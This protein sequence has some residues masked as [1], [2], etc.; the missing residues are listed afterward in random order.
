M[1]YLL[2]R[3]C[4]SSLSCVNGCVITGRGGYVSELSS[5]SNCSTNECFPDKSRWLWNEK[6]FLHQ[7]E[8]KIAHPHHGIYELASTSSSIFDSI[9]LMRVIAGFN[10]IFVIFTITVGICR[11]YCKH[12][13]LQTFLLQLLLFTINLAVATTFHSIT[14]TNH[15]MST[16]AN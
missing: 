2:E 4:H 16:F 12:V 1:A 7:F 14:L 10:H 13:L 5:R 3:R 15:K 8:A 9:F 6:F 11:F